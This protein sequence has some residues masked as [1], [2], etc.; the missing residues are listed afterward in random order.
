MYSF[1]TSGNYVIFKYTEDHFPNYEHEVFNLHNTSTCIDWGLTEDTTRITF[2]ID[3]TRYENVPLSSIE[4]DDVVCETQQD[5]IDG[6]QGMFE[7]LAAPG[8]G[9]S[10]LVA[11]VEL[12]DAQ[13]K[14]LKTTGIDV[15]TAP[16]ANKI[17]L[18]VSFAMTLDTTAGVYTNISA[19][20]HLF[21]ETDA[22]YY[23][24]LIGDRAAE[25]LTRLTDFITY[26]A[27][28][29][30]FGNVIQ[31]VY[32]ANYETL[33]PTVLEITGLINKAVRIRVINSGG[34]YTGGNAL[35]TFKIT[36]GYLI[37][38]V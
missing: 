29:F 26:N 37:I 7:N 2:T 25:T 15:I 33:V 32:S 28:A 12:T 31:G 4:F 27:V 19:N 38:D 11:T 35:N 17:A 21:L 14:A 1:I 6:V 24:L 30:A 36:V 34:N 5:F 10:Y 3:E 18:P 8:G 20:S 22:G 13:F 9:S 16:G 23:G